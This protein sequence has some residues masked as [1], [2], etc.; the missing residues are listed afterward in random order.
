M[1]DCMC[2]IKAY[3]HK[4]GGWWRVLREKNHACHAPGARSSHGLDRISRIGLLE[5]REERGQRIMCE[6][7]KG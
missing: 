5:V 7:G 6:V 3:R 2:I 4:G 1:H